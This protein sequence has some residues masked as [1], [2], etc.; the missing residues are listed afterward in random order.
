[1]IGS[2]GL[3]SELQVGIFQVFKKLANK[4]DKV[5]CQYVAKNVI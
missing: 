1:M 2:G 5:G 3:I 4:T